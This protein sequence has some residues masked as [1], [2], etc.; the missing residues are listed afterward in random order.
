MVKTEL[1]H[2]CIHSDEPDLTCPFAEIIL[3]ET[4]CSQTLGWMKAS[5]NILELKKCFMTASPRDK[6]SM[7]NKL[8]KNP[9]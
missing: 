1:F 8:Q 6:V 9:G 3:D 2:E 5:A 7:V 4:H